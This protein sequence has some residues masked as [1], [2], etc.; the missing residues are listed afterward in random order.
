MAGNHS[1]SSVVS[2]GAAARL[3][4]E[5]LD[6]AA[7]RHG[8]AAA[9]RDV[10]GAWTYAALS[11]A[12]KAAAH[13]LQERGVRSGDRV[14]A[15]AYPKRHVVALL[16]GC[17]RL[18]ATFVPVS[19]DMA[20]YQ[21]DAVLA[22][23]RP[24]LNLCD[25]PD[26]DAAAAFI[27]H[28]TDAGADAEPETL[29]EPLGFD[30]RSTEPAQDLR[31]SADTALLLLTSGSTAVPKAVVCPHRQILFAT[32][33]IARRLRY[34]PDDV[35]YSRLPLSFDYGL[36]QVFLSTQAAAELVL[37][38]PSPA[39]DVRLLSALHSAGATVLPL[40]P[41]LA[42]MLVRLAQRPG[43]R[44]PVRLFTNTGEH[45]SQQMARELRTSFPGAGLHMMYGM[46]EC[47][48]I[49][50]AERDADLERPGT[51]GKALDGTK[52]RISDP[53][54]RPLPFGQVGEIQVSGPH[55]MAGYWEAPELTA[56]VFGQD[57]ET[58]QPLLRTGDFGRMDAD[59]HLYFEGRR[60][61]IFKQ[62]GVRTSA[63]EIETAAQTL[64]GVH[65]AVL[66]TPASD[67]AAV[68][69]VLGD[70]RQEMVQRE[71]RLLLGPAKVPALCRVFSKFPLTANGKVDRTRLAALV[72]GGQTR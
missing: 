48:R 12:S 65:S 13:W 50:V 14:T 17:S 4:H 11:A 45:L 59:G 19:V 18:G 40:V 33:A 49:T 35:V 56:R 1:D 20:K 55:V 66:L 51:V 47:K 52:V 29:P 22:D 8:K 34:Q 36:Y 46:T 42:A 3:L 63:V 68:L 28:A 67:S 54:G 41:S 71:L 37:A 25:T 38:E 6:R 53:E 27:E 60:D 70:V 72:H 16:Y 69:C 64:P 23:I 44:P 2:H 39:A 10:S 43:P 62:R 7:Q 30:G 26:F 9:L 24:A 57:P 61:H 15:R 21:L 58:G 32:D 31:R 5:P